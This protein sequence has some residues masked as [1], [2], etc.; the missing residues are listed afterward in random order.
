MPGPAT[1]APSPIPQVVAE[2]PRPAP[3]PF[4]PSRPRPDR[5]RFRVRH[6]VLAILIIAALA[7]FASRRGPPPAPLRIAVGPAWTLVDL[8]AL[9]ASRL[10]RLS[11]DAPFTLRLDGE[12]MMR[13]APGGST[14][15]RPGT[16]RELALRSGR[17]QVTV[18]LAPRDE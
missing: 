18:V 8:S 3:K 14:L 9:R 7:F 12:R 13:V 17:G 4:A 6:A 11:A 10:V 15:I 5:R 16:L 2:A 1:R